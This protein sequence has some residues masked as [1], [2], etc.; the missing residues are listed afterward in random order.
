MFVM[1]S[2]SLKMNSRTSSRFDCFCLLALNV[3]V[4]CS[5]CIVEL[6]LDSSL[7]R[8]IFEGLLSN[9]G[10]CPRPWLRFV[11]VP[12]KVPVSADMV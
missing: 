5:L 6:T 3:D 8:G 9:T 1:Q 2:L 7:G 10:I 11:G 12:R 4:A